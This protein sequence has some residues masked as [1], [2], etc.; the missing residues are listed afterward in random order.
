MKSASSPQGWV[1]RLDPGDEIPRDVLSA[2]AALGVGTA[3]VAGIGAVDRAVVALYD[4][5]ERRYVETVLDEELEIVSLQGNIVRLDGAPFLH[6]HCVL[7]RRDGQAVGGH[8]MSARTSITVE[9]FLTRFAIE[10][11]RTLAPFCGLKLLDF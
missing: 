5:K 1:I 9:L 10:A 8:L 11:T 6:A 2:A 7:T 3:S 4:L